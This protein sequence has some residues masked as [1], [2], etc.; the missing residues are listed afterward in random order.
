MIYTVTLNPSIDYVIYPDDPIELG[1]LN[2]FE[3]DQKSAGGKGINVSRILTQLNTD[4]VA[5]G[6]VG[7]RIGQLL[8]DQLHNEHV[9][10]DFTQPLIQI[11]ASM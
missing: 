3:K 5:M 7:G 6:F 2:R 1:Q 11:R 10:T 4:N 9:N 8:T